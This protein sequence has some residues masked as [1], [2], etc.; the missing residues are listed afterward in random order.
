M[1]VLV[2]PRS[3]RPWPVPSVASSYAELRRALDQPLPRAWR[4]VRN[5][6][7][8]G[9]ASP[10]PSHAA[11]PDVPRSATEVNAILEALPLRQRLIAGCA[12]LSTIADRWIDWATGWVGPES[13]EFLQLPATTLA[14]VRELLGRR[15]NALPRLKTHMQA[16]YAMAARMER[17]QWGVENAQ[18]ARAIGVLHVAARLADLGVQL[19]R[20]EAAESLSDGAPVRVSRDDALAHN[21]AELVIASASSDGRGLALERWWRRLQA[22][23]PIADV[24]SATLE[25]A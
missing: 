8:P 20:I 15:P 19:A 5:D 4:P 9:P 3:C 23:L 14:Y 11:Q 13:A 7:S 6:W 10:P 24:A 12:V 22:A 16:L 1:V 17:D 21:V 2:S 25:W 18:A